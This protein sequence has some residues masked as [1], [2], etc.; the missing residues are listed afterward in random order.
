MLHDT[1][2]VNERRHQILEAAMQ[3]FSRKGY[4]KAT[5]K[6]IADAAGGISPGLIYHYFKDKEDLFFSI[7]RERAS[8]IQL[9]DHPE[10]FM[11]LPLRDALTTLGRTYLQMISSPQNLAFFRIVLS[12]ALRFPQI[13][14][15][16]YRVLLGRVFQIFVR[17]F[18]HQID[19]G[20]MK[21]CDP[22]IAVRSFIGMFI[23]HIIMRDLFLQPEAQAISNETVVAQAVNT[24][25]Y[26]LELTS[27]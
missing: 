19:I 7:V 22:T 1:P 27:G 4:Q 25:L 21:P 8:V 24:F 13:S 15:T 5:N 23:A 20:H 9:A 2:E 17:Y 14:E 12:E 18:Q 11:D 3:V 10:Q 26:G 6:D 16:F